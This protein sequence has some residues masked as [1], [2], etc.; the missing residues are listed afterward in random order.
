M[1]VS[2]R[3]F[4]DWLSVLLFSVLSLFVMQVRN[5]IISHFGI[6]RYSLLFIEVVI[7][8]GTSWQQIV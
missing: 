5:A 2:L 1:V 6:Y 4:V 7:Q 8:S 3:D